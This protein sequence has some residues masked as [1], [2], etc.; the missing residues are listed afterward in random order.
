[1][2]HLLNIN[3][4]LE[5]ISNPEAIQSSYKLEKSCKDHA[6]ASKTL[7]DKVYLVSYLEY[8]EE[9]YAEHKPILIT[10]QLN[11]PM[12]IPKIQIKH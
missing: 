7:A 10:L 3:N 9:Y 11:K 8:P 4:N 12:R 2:V 5:L 1:M 6:F